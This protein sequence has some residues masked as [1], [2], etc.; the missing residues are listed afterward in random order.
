[1]ATANSLDPIP[2]PLLDSMAIIE[3]G[4]YTREEN[5]HIHKEHLLKKQLKKH[6]LKGTQCRIPDEVLYAIIDGYTREAGVRELE[7]TI[8]TLCRKAR[9]V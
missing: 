8:G 2:A 4:R 3:L 1:M 5:F 9:C 7:R 6:G